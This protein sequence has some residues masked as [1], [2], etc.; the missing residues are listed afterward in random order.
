[1]HDP[2]CRREIETAYTYLQNALVVKGSPSKNYD[3]VLDLH[4]E[5][6]QMQWFYYYACHKERCLFWLDA[7]DAKYM[8]SEVLWVGPHTHVSAYP[9][10]SPI[11][12]LFLLIRFSE[13]RLEDLYWYF[14]YAELDP[15]CMD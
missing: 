8:L 13:H 4:E 5:G 10:L 11:Y 15:E 9:I 6:G 12:Y 3:L 1:M 2:E 7:Y 14:C